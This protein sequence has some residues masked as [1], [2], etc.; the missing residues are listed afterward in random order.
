[1]TLLSLPTPIFDRIAP[2]PTTGCWIWEGHINHAGY[3]RGHSQGHGQQNAHRLVYQLLVG[4]IPVQHEVHHTCG[5]RSCVNP[6]HLVVMPRRA[7]AQHHHPKQ[8]AC[9]R[10]HAFTKENTY[11]ARDG[12]QVCRTCAHMYQST[13]TSRALKTAAQRA[14]RADD[15]YRKY[16]RARENE[17][18]RTRYTTDAAY[19]ERM[20]QR[21]H[22]YY[23]NRKKGVM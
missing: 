16:W 10:G 14:R 6:A 18:A 8:K 22:D 19:R 17:T 12:T 7:H 20:K 23:H 2:C 15:E 4:P 9:I 3:G 5:V 21:A 1:M 13:P 11:I